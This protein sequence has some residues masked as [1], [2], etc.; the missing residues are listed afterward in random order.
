MELI[1]KE[2]LINAKGTH[3]EKLFKRFYVQDKKGL[4]YMN[5]LKEILG[6]R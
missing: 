1:M 3:Y 2:L 6:L 5:I 4:G